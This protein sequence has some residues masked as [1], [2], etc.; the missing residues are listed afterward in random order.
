ML[1]IKFF[2]VFDHIKRIQEYRVA[3]GIHK[4]RNDVSDGKTMI[5][6]HKI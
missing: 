5:L 1:A 4:L 3:V 2:S 6:I